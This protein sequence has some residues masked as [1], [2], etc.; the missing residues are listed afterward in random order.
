MENSPHLKRGQWRTGKVVAVFPGEDGL[1]RAVDVEFDG[2]IYRR[3]IQ[4][5]C[6]LEP[7]SSDSTKSDSGEKCPSEDICQNS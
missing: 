3:G 6:L 2:V 5:L 4:K 7:S 1:V